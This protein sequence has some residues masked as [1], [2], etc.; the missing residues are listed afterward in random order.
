MAES[1]CRVVVEFSWSGSRN[2]SMGKPELDNVTEFDDLAERLEALDAP[3]A[4]VALLIEA[5]AAPP[6]RQPGIND[7]P[8]LLARD[9]E[10]WAGGA[11]P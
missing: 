2:I 3:T 9:G 1:G 8:D 11:A 6:P 10:P 5:A 4:C 7:C